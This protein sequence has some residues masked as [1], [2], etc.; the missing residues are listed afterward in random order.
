M[1]IHKIFIL[2]FVSGMKLTISQE[3]RWY[4]RRNPGF[5]L[6]D[7][8]DDCS[9]YSIMNDIR[10]R[11]KDG[12]RHISKATSKPQ[13]STICIVAITGMIISDIFTID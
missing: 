11:G 12:A 5:Q 1:Q 9:Q 2:N 10:Y 13:D 3:A 7:I 8:L 4:E 6:I